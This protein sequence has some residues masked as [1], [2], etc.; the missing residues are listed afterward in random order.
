MQEIL[1]NV[2]IDDALLASALA[3][4]RPST[5]PWL[6]TARNYARYANEGGVYDELHDYLKQ[7]GMA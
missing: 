7:V 5:R 3:D 4:M 6:E 2:P 1:I